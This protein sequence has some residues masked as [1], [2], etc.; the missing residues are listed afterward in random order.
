MLDL[1]QA[2][3]AA[4]FNC[5]RCLF[6]R[7]AFRATAQYR[8]FILLAPAHWNMRTDTDQVFAYLSQLDSTLSRTVMQGAVTRS[9]SADKL[10]M[11]LSGEVLLTTIERNRAMASRLIAWKAKS[12][13]SAAT[14]I[15][16]SLFAIAESSLME[17]L[18]AGLF[19]AWPYDHRQ[20]VPTSE[21]EQCSPSEIW[22]RLTSLASRCFTGMQTTEGARLSL[23]SAIEWELAVCP[24]HPF[25]DGCGRVSRYF[26]TLLC[27]WSEECPRVH[28]C[29]TIYLE[30]AR[31]GRKA[32]ES[33]YAAL[34]PSPIFGATVGSSPQ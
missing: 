18:P 28:P 14:D 13:P 24:L 22:E 10:P 23:V 27:L 12:P 4:K 7:T 32:F 25:Y 31:A 2:E 5:K 30:A 11:L 16:C 9:A 3:D 21:E 15:L 17:I 8:R 29:R 34:Q 20:Y 33:Y 26:S 19:R 6:G 1:D